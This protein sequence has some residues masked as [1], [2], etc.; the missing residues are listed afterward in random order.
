MDEMN[1]DNNRNSSDPTETMHVLEV[2]SQYS[3]P[4]RQSAWV[5]HLPGL[6]GSVVVVD[7]VVTGALVVVVRVV[8]CVDV[9]EPHKGQTPSIASI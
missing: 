9:V 2:L 1:Q 8:E 5:L 4:T 7:A 3:R 6:L